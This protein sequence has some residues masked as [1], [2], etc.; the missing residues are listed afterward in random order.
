MERSLSKIK[1]HYPQIVEW[2]K[3]RGINFIESIYT[4]FSTRFAGEYFIESDVPDYKLYYLFP[5]VF[6]SAC[7]VKNCLINC[8]LSKCRY[9]K[10]FWDENQKILRTCSFS[11]NDIEKTAQDIFTSGRI[12]NGKIVK[13]CNDIGEKNEQPIFV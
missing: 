13:L 4:K 10:E 5:H 11:E 1:K 3:K 6:C 9:W 12:S 8:D 7:H 2:G